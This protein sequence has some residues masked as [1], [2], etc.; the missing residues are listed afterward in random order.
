MDALTILATAV[1][2]LAVANIF[3]GDHEWAPYLALP[4][5]FI[6]IAYLLIAG[7]LHALE[8]TMLT[9]PVLASCSGSRVLWG[10]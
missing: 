2:I 8:R 9:G 1:G 4:L 10:V 3:L 6:A 7:G 5:T